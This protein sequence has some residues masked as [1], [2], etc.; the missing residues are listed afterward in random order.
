MK[1]YRKP[2]VEEIQL[3]CKR[4]AADV[5]ELHA[6]VSEIMATVKQ[7]GD[8]AL[9]K[10]TSRFDGVQLTSDD[11][12]VTA[13]EFDEA[14][15]QISDELKA[16]IQLAASNIEKFHAAQLTQPK[17][18]ETMPGVQCWRKQ[19]PIE[20]VGLYVPGGTA[21]LFSSVLMLGV[22]AKVAGCKH[23]VLCTPPQKDGS[24]HPAV[25]YAAQLAEVHA[26]YKVGGAQAIA[27]MAYGTPAIP[28]VDK[29]FGPGNAYV[30]AAKQLAQ[31]GGLAIDMPA[32]PSE[33][34]VVADASAEPEIIAA[35][36]LSQAEHGADS[37]VLLIT[38]EGSL[39]EAVQSAVNQQLKGLKRAEAA[40]KALEHS[41]LVHVG[42]LSEALALVD[43]YAPEHLILHLDDA[44]HFADQVSHAGS[45][46]I[47][48]LTP[49]S[50]GDYASGTNHTLPTA[51]YVR[52]YA[53]CSLDS[54]VR[55]VT[56]QQVDEIGFSNLAEAVVTLA[57]AESL[58]AHA[59]AVRVRQRKFN[60]S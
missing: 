44:K 34:C 51:G 30:T 19:L 14:E 29:L 48:Q 1:I 18:I 17:V 33:V 12:K 31:L 27:A 58:G 5:T 6:S 47:G 32:G 9:V 56:F 40:Q 39:I 45:V 35:D 24:V 38:T 59:E 42:S 15:T 10:F 25:L 55:Q 21:P 26:V 28:K 52:A 3:I 16:A 36:L 13:A 20:K 2:T 37:Q 22:P 53:G 4:P 46:F 23:R 7:E 41:A 54:F 49:E 43:A 11:L 57:E 60:L 50:F 8:A